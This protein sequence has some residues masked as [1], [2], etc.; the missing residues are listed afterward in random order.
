[1]PN[2]IPSVVAML[3]CET[4]I[5]DAATG[6]KTLVNLFETFSATSDFP[7]VAQAFALY[8]KLT[9]MEGHYAMRI[10]L[11]SLEDEQRL[12]SF[13]GALDSADRLRTY[14]LAVLFSPGIK[15]E[16]PGRYEFQLYADEVFVGRCT[17]KLERREVSQ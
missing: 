16:R 8:A 5:T 14:D 9:D 11:V 13:T 15:F 3:L 7:Q 1:M 2:P 17:L 6:R 12:V 4:I 10:D